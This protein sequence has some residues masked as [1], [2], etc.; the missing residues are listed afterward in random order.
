MLNAAQ[1][2]VKC[3]RIS[4]EC[5]RGAGSA[6]DVYVERFNERMRLELQSVTQSDQAAAI[7]VAKQYGYMT[8]S[9]LEQSRRAVLEGP[10]ASQGKTSVGSADVTRR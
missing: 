9:E 6:Y 2:M 3:E 8:A 10:V 1:W 4:V 7:E 5:V